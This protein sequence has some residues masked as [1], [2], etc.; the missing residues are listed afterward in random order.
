MA[1][2]LPA[3]YT[4]TGCHAFV[5][6]ENAWHLADW[7]RAMR[8]VK[9]L[10][11][12]IVKAVQAGKWRK[13]KALQRILSRSYAAKLLAVRRVTENSGHRT[14]GI[15]GQRWNTPKAR[16]KAVAQLQRRAYRAK[17]VRR[18]YIPKPNGKKR[19]LGIPT[20]H[21]RAQQALHLLT[22]DPISETLADANSYGFRPYRCCADA[23]ARCFDILSKRNA[24]QW[25]LEGDIKG[26]FDNISH[27]WLLENIP[28]D[29][30][31]LRRWLKAG[32]FEKRTLF[33][34]ESGTPQGA[35]ISPCLAN[36]ALDG[37]QEAI[38]QASGVKYWG[39]QEPRRRI[40]PHQTHLIRYADDFVVICSD[41]SVLEHRIKPAIQSFLAE[42]GL[43]LSEEKT[44]LTHLQEG[45]DFL[46]QNV[47]KYK[48]KLLIKPS[49][50][51]V[52][53]F[54]QKVKVTIK[55][56]SA[57]NAVDL[58]KVLAPAIRGWA[59]YHR[60]VVSKATFSK[61]DNQIWQMLW[62]WSR[63]RHAHRKNLAWIKNRYFMR[64]KGRD[65][66]FFAH[67]EHGNLVTIFR[68]ASVPIRRHIKIRGRANPYDT[69]QEVY[70]EQ[71]SDQLMQQKLEG[72][73]MITYLYKRQQG[74]CPAC[75]QKI[76]EQTGWNA[77][78]LT[79]KYLGGQWSTDNLALLHPVCHIQVHQNQEKA[80]AL[81]TAVGVQN[82]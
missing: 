22:L 31:M 52:H 72:K 73:R 10:Q 45:F 78:H 58:L 36:M 16:F 76:T 1:N 59:L 27:L 68:A 66:T 69:T 37:L 18:I 39:R 60:H 4:M 51:A 33:P 64:Y 63:R 48:D 61:V 30:R 43:E 75:R 71:R 40:N 21:D 8:A 2:C 23:I 46:S 80:A 32:Y 54:L 24:P 57:S 55:M 6:E 20:M 77:H 3:L 67:D 42:R 15:D 38:D 26:C 29:R 49:Q 50:K 9:S 53:R 56:Y 14:A 79:P 62:R 47:R 13:V 19:A 28:L 5:T 44:H 70:F 25:I 7:G 34:S 11:N 12:R 17:P 81:M 74:L 82:A 65:W 41:K 35:I